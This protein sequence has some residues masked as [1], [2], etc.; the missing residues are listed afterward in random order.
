MLKVVATVAIA[1]VMLVALSATVQAGYLDPNHREHALRQA[2]ELPRRG[3]R[4]PVH[5]AD[6]HHPS[7]AVLRRHAMDL[8]AYGGLPDR[9]DRHG[10]GPVPHPVLDLGRGQFA[11]AVEFGADLRCVRE[12]EG[13]D[14]GTCPLSKPTSTP[15]WCRGSRARSWRLTSSTRTGRPEN[16]RP[17]IRKGRDQRP[18]L[19]P[20]GTLFGGGGAYCAGADRGDS[21]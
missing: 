3:K 8:S 21:T 5:G 9:I 2:A 7:I 10:A 15:A 1:A 11:H 14:A 19:P 12:V 17:S 20:K 4:L 6:A 13:S 18:P 16:T